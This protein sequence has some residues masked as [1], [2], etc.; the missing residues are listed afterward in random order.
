MSADNIEKTFT[1]DPSNWVNYEG[2]DLHV[3]KGSVTLNTETGVVR[4]GEH[5]LELLVDAV[6]GVRT[7]PNCATQAVI[8]LASIA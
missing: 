4:C 6:T 1:A 3:D 5:F 7:C 8:Q 2:Y